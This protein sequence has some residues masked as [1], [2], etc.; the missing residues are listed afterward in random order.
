MEGSP[1]SRTAP[2]RR[3]ARRGPLAL[4]A[5]GVVAAL[6]GAA[7]LLGARST[8]TPARDVEP[9]AVARL[10]GGGRGRGRPR[11]WALQPRRA[12]VRDRY[13]LPVPRRHHGRLLDE[14]HAGPAADR[15][16]R[17]RRAGGRPVRDEPVPRRPV[18]D[19]RPGPAV[20]LRRRASLGR[21]HRR[22]HPRGRPGG[23]AGPRRPPSSVLKPQLRR[24]LNW[25]P[26][27]T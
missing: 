18:P 6:A 19:L 9:G 11:A 4:A 3:L 7:F 20:P 12:A 15:L 2:R 14:G 1:G 27:K 25:P 26:Y 17:R 21:F 10:A 24:Q 16:R 13:G 5:I 8:G 22:R 23:P